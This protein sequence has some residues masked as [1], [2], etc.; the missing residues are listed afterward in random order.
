M[1]RASAS[2]RRVREAMDSVL[3]HD[4]KNLGFRLRLLAS[5]LDRSF[6]DP[7]FKRVA[8]NALQGAVE[9]LDATVSRWSA[10]PAAVLIKVPLDLNDLVAEV[11]RTALLRDGSSPSTAL[12]AHL[13]EVP[14]AWGD[15]NYLRE[16]LSSVVLNAFEAAGP[17]GCVT[18]TTS[19]P[20][21]GR[22]RAVIQVRDDGPGMA[23]PFLENELF[24]PFRT[25]KQD[26]VGLGL[27]T[28]RE[29]VRLH[30]GTIGVRS[31]PG[32]GTLV[33]ISLPAGDASR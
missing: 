12:E 24:Q 9:K 20:A 6:G 1:P 26:G 31:A 33:R 13:G 25:T 7:E 2:G 21:R 8:L 17:D 28:A 4:L 23:A 15:P 27:Y 19:R 5:N 3:L 14:R 30:G 10:P 32:A 16:A 29:I 22:P 11:L 18:V